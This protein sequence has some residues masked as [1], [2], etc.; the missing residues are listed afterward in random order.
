MVM[1]EKNLHAPKD[2]I[3]LNAMQ[4]YENII[5]LENLLYPI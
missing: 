2:I 3:G 5:P 1:S 4:S